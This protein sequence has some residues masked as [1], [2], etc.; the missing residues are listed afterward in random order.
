LSKRNWLAL[1]ASASAISLT[2]LGVSTAAGALTVNTKTQWQAAI[3][4]VPAPG[5]GCYNATYPKLQWHAVTC[6]TAPKW[7]FAPSTVGNGIDY[8][9]QVAGTI[10]TATGTFTGVSS[11]ISEKGQVNGQG[12][13]IANAFSLQLNTEFFSGSP[14][15]SGSS[16]PSDCLAWQQFVYAYVDGGMI[17]M[18][19]W[20]IDYN[21]TCPAGWNTFTVSSTTDCYTNSEAAGVVHLTAKDLATVQVTGSA[22]TGGNDG[23]SLALGSGKATLVTGPDSMVDLAPH[24]NTTEWDVFGDAG[25]GEA[26]FGSANTLEAQTALKG[27]SPAAPKCVKE[28]F[29][30]ETN[31]LK[32]ASTSA[33]GSEPSPTMASRQTDGSAG[34]ASCAVKA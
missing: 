19:Y 22:V 31:N 28:G 18:Q 13:K 27:T 17:F 2:L 33:L 7:R 5:T 16:D 10:S 15:C 8:S 4:Q 23:L 14:A 30:G 29:T 21:A 1:V 12:A 9:A 24:W 32:L 34:T 26:Y 6:V 11:D 25:G 20:L 3:G